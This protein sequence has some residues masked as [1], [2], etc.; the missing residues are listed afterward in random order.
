MGL[1][2]FH[3][4]FDNPQAVYYAGQNVSGKV[5][6]IANT[7]KKI[8]GELT[9]DESGMAKYMISPSESA[10]IPLNPLSVRDGIVL[11]LYK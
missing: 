4:V 1:E 7:P 8:R 2:K 3:I 5:V 10:H 6:I 11:F 9:L